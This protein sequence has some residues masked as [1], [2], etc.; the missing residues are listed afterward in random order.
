MR[1]YHQLAP[2]EANESLFEF[3]TAGK[4]R[5]SKRPETG[6]WITTDMFDVESMMIDILASLDSQGCCI[7]IAS[8]QKSVGCF[9]RCPALVARWP[10]VQLPS[11]VVFRIVART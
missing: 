6:R 11:N 5:A 9:A 8:V 10:V 4:L 7:H 1:E 2:N 3:S